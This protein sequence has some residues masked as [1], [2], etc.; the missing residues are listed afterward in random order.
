MA[1]IQEAT[2]QI[3]KL[4][5]QLSHSTLQPYLEKNPQLK[6]AVNDTLQQLTQFGDKYGPEAKKVADDT[7]KQIQQLA[8]QGLTAGTI[9]KAASLA[10]EKL[11]EIQELGAKAGS[12]AYSKAA[13]GARP[14]LEKA[15]DVKKY[16]EDYLG[17]MKE[18]VGDDGVKLINDT[19]AELEK[20]GKKGDSES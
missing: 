6:S 18:Y 13:E 15:P 1:A 9:A 16:L 17:S 7:V 19:Y 11:K 2:N 12:D 4:S 5:T 20:A 14:Y 8:D 10:K 3:Q